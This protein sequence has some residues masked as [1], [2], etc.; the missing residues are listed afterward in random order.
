VFEVTVC[1]TDP[2]L[3]HWTVLLT[4]ITT[5]MFLGVKAKSTILTVAFGAEVVLQSTGG[6]DAVTPSGRV[7]T[8]ASRANRD[9]TTMMTTARTEG[10]PRD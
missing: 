8:L 2:V 4:P 1:E 10:A 3:L 7:E 5:T 9:S 6:A